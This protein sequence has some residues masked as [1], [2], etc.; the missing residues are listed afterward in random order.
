[1]KNFLEKLNNCEEKLLLVFSSF[2][3]MKDDNARRLLQNKRGER[4]RDVLEPVSNGQTKELKAYGGS[5]SPKMPGD[6]ERNGKVS[7]SY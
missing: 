6:L 1:M 3:L 5:N 7:K 4:K 2:I